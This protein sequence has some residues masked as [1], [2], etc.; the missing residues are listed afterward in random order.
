MSWSAGQSVLKRLL[1]TVLGLLCTQVCCMTGL[2]VKQS[3]PDLSLQEGLSCTLQCN[4]STSV[5]RVQWFRQN[6]GGH[7]IHLF[8]I[9]SG[10]KQNG[11]LRSTTVVEDRRS[12]LYISS[13]RTTDSAIYFSSAQ[14]SPGTCC[15]YP[16]LKLWLQPSPTVR[17]K[18]SHACAKSDWPQKILDTFK[19]TGMIQNLFSDQSKMDSEGQLQKKKCLWKLSSIWNLSLEL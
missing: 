18:H 8:Y 5:T 1:V 3:P 2:M 15:L 4:F 9:P 10:T 11:R 19:R 7:L 14:C 12:L 6:P 16:N 13:L 17:R